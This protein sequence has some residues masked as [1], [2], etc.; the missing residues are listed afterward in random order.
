MASK[1]CR[2][3]MDDAAAGAVFLQHGLEGDFGFLEEKQESLGIYEGIIVGTEP[4][5]EAELESMARVKVIHKF[6]VGTD[7]IDLAP[8]Q[9]RGIAVISL[10]GINSG[11]VAEMAFGLM[12]A[13]ARRICEGDRCV[14]G[15][16]WAR[17]KGRSL[18]GKTLG[19]IGTGAIG[20]ALCALVSGFN[21]NIVGFDLCENQN[22]T[23]MG[24]RYT[25]LSDLLKEADFISIHVP[26]TEQTR[27]LIGRTELSLV[28]NTAIIVNT[29]RGG[30][31]DEGALLEFLVKN[32][33]AGAAFDVLEDESGRNNPFREL[34]NVI[35]TPHIAAYDYDTLARMFDVTVNNL[36]TF[37]R[38]GNHA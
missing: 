1:T 17:I 33:G 29:A 11:A 21:M 38:D 15:G 8:A 28:K 5:G 26:L 25:G 37:F 27:G 9:K 6:G 34:D 32:S 10:P 19:I 2:T 14:R 12:L 3:V 13:A 20:R 22:F 31:V 16:S 23:A 24:G 7:N 18:S 36:G 4:I 35:V 30:I